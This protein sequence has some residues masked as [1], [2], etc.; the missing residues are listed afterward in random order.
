MQ[1][2]AARANVAGVVWPAAAE[3]SPTGIS[4]DA[5]KRERESQRPNGRVGAVG[6]DGA[7]LACFPSFLPSFL[8][9]FRIVITGTRLESLALWHTLSLSPNAHVG[10]SPIEG[11]QFGE[12]M[13]GYHNAAIVAERGFLSHVTT[14]ADMS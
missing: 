8:P 2:S 9:P 14:I 6:I 4:L 11:L 12:G 10:K 1:C 5:Q 7:A 13:D 3:I